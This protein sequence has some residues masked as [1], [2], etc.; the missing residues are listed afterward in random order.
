MIKIGL[1]GTG[2][3]ARDHAQAI[4]MIPQAAR[5]VA[6]ADTSAER[7]A[8]FA[9]MFDVSRRY[10]AAAELIA[11]PQVDLVVIATPPSAHEEAVIAALEAN[12]YVLC[13]KPLAQS[14]ASAMRIAA[15]EVRHPGR[16]ASG[17]QLRYAA[18]FRR[19]LWLC[20]NGW[21]GDL[22]SARVERH[23][24]IPHANVAAGGWWGAWAVAGGGVLMTQ[25][26]HQ[27]DML[28]AIMGPP[29]SIRAQMDTRFTAIESEDWIDSTIRFESGS[30]ARCI[31]SVNSGRSD[32][33]FVVSGSLGS[34]DLSGQI[35]MNDPARVADAT[36]AVNRA[37]PDT[38]P[39]ARTIVARI[40]NK[41]SRKLGVQPMKPLTPHARFY[42]DIAQCIGEGKPLPIPASEGLKSLELCAAA[43]QAALDGKEITFPLAAGSP[44]YNGLS[45]EDYKKRPASALPASPA[46]KRLARRAKWQGLR[47]GMIGLDTTHAPTITKLLH[48]PSAPHHIP[49]ARVVAA[50]PGGSPDMPISITRV[51]Q[52]TAELRSYGVDIVGSPEDVADACDIVFLHAADGRTHPGLFQA[53]AGRCQ[54][55]F[56]DK[57]LATSNADA[58]RMFALAEKTGTRLF[59]TS[60]FRYAD[61]LVT[62]LESIRESGEQVKSCQ[63]RF[64]LQIQETQGRYF[65]YGIHAS[66]MLHAVMG[67]GVRAVESVNGGD[68]DTIHVWHED[69]RESSL[70]GA[71]NDG[72]FHVT[73]KTDRRKLEIDLASS[74]PSVTARVTSAAFDVLT[75]GSYPRLWGASGTGSVCGGR[76]GHPR[77]PDVAE[78]RGVIRLLDAAQ[79]SFVSR[80]KTAI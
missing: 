52:F 2:A 16:L 7:L 57:P 30:A 28:L 48:D 37:L 4:A 14:M 72:T 41:I 31:A 36:D 18:E 77:D 24:Y 73:I 60:A 62:A 22:Q 67:K 71:L 21:I 69:G 17:Y 74:L 50:F 59:S 55:V 58:D 33:A 47:V 5:L 65:W 32:G 6:A 80:Q 76:V 53:V 54:A 11:D 15:C 27:L 12:K 23:S 34:I 63:I 79:L 10:N 8:E 45:V 68:K 43:Y 35:K 46:P 39:P 40:I 29:K 19:L 75:E 26:I 1:I 44:A 49:G 42:R 66:D 3:I 56:V 78:T 64:W 20:R 61:G 38:V 70:I 51:P 9:T 13:E 25:V